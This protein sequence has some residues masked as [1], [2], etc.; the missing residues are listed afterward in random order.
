MDKNETEL[1]RLLYTRIG[2]VMEDNSVIAL[3]LGGQIDGLDPTKI[4]ELERAVRQISALC[5]AARAMAAS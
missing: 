2:M 3:E 5:D 1:V 4:G